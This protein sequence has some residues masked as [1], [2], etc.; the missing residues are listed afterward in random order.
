MIRFVF[1]LSLIFIPAIGEAGED[2]LAVLKKDQPADV[3]KMVDRLVGCAHWAGEEPYDA[4]REKQI[5]KAL[6]ELK[7][8]RLDR[9]YQAMMKLYAKQP[10]VLDALKKAHDW[11]Y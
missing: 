6:K 8:D 3:A 1:Y 9:D 2:P 10:K 11:S 7:C 4:Q 5:R